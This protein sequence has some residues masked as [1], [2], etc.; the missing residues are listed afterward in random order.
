MDECRFK[1]LIVWKES[2]LL[3]QALYRLTASFPLEE[4]FRE[5]RGDRVGLSRRDRNP[6]RNCWR[7]QLEL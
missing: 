5:V 3:A 4:R 2:V 1:R 6:A 7:I